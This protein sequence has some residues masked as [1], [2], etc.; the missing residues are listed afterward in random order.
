MYVWKT[1]RISTS[2][3]VRIEY[4]EYREMKRWR[5]NTRQ[6]N[7]KYNKKEKKEKKI[8]QQSNGQGLTIVAIKQAIGLKK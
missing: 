8:N 1:E 2:I 6:K 5:I 7:F 3:R 4:N